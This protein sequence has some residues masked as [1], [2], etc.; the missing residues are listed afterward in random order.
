MRIRL[1]RK[2]KTQLG[3]T[4]PV[5]RILTVSDS[6]GKKIIAEGSAEKYTGEY[7]PRKKMKFDLKNLT[8]GKN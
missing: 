6:Y 7:P 8:N 4:Y 1:L 3:F 2:Y 5:G